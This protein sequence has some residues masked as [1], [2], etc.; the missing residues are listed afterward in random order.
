MIG[1]EVNVYLKKEDGFG[2][3]GNVVTVDD[4]RDVE[5]VLLEAGWAVVRG[6]FSEGGA[7]WYL[8]LEAKA[9]QKGRGIHA[10]NL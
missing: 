4:C 8:A 6:E 1:R 7:G 2:V 5:G 9:R 10:K 3:T